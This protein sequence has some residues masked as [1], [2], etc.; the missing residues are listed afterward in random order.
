MPGLVFLGTPNFAVPCLQK[1][2]ECNAGV[3]LVIT[4]PDRPSGRGR[5]IC[6]SPV[7]TLANEA[8]IPI[9]QPERIRGGEVIEKIRTYGAECA[10]VVAFGQLVPQS[11][12]DIF[13]LGTLNVHGSLLPR[14]RGA[15]PIQRAILAGE[16][17]T[18]ISIMLL[19]AGMDTGPVLAQKEVSIGPDDTFG[20]VYKTLAEHGAELLID[21]LRDWTAGRLAPLVQDDALATYAPPI[22]KEE[23]RIDWNSP[24]KDIINKVRAFDPAPGAWFALGGKRVKCFRAASFPWAATGASGEVVGMADCGLIVAGGC[25]QS[26]CIGDLQLE[27]LRRMRA[28]EFTC[29]RPIPRGSFLE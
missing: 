20:T 4:Q 8:G 23:L 18:G 29:G 10:V 5:R 16:T 15:A 17:L 28:C 14:Y 2:L 24:A 9:Y 22:H 26:L 1:L 13:P 25:G 6:E 11:F 21:T 3:R 27:G 19:D 12:L 7:K